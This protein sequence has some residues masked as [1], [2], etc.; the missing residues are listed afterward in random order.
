ML[1]LCLVLGPFLELITLLCG[2]LTDHPIVHKLWELT[3]YT[4][5]EGLEAMNCCYEGLQAM[6]FKNLRS[7]I[8]NRFLLGG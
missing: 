2:K 5:V 1:L 7:F 6:H 8:N 4:G 3:T